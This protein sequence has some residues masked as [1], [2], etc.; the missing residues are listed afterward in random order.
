MEQENTKSEL[1]PD[2]I[3]DE[4]IRQLLAKPES[5]E[6][7]EIE[8]FGYPADYLDDPM[9]K[10]RRLREYREIERDYGKYIEFEVMTTCN[11]NVRIGIAYRSKAPLML[12]DFGIRKAYI[13][14]KKLKYLLDVYASKSYMRSF[15]NKETFIIK[16]PTRLLLDNSNVMM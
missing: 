3:V 7:L 14:T 10:R 1:N 9:Q 15:G 2:Q 8:L 6:E 16:L 13:A 5:D 11:G 4:M 12:L